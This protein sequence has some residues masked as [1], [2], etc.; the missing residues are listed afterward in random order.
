MLEKIQMRLRP[1]VA[2]NADRLRV[3]V[4]SQLDVDVNRIKRVDIL[5]R[6]IDARRRQVAVN[7]SVAVH[8]DSVD[9]S[10]SRYVPVEYPDVSGARQVIVV[11]AGPAGLFAA[12]ELI[13]L[14]LRPVVLERGKDVDSRRRDMADL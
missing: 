1:E 13:E 2:G 5:R 9:E 11:G 10:F 8:L 7:L 6:S 3:A 4:S 12:L 14:G